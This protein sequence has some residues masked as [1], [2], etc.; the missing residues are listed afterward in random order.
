[1]ED[2]E[3]RTEE[4][5]PKR[6]RE[7]REKGQVA[8][9]GDLN[10]AVFFFIFT[11]LAGV[12]SQYILKNALNYLEYAL[13]GDFHISLSSNNVA[14]LLLNHMIRFVIFLLPFILIVLVVGIG[15]NLMQIG[16]IFTFEPIKPDLKRLNP[17][18]GFKNLFSKKA[19]FGLI[20]NILKLSLVLYLAYSSLNKSINSVI[21][22]SKLGSQKLFPFFVDFAKNVAF[23][24]AIVM[25]LLGIL[26]F[27]VERREYKKN[28]R[29]S[30]RELKDEFKEM[31]GS[32]EIKT[33]RQQRQ[34]QLAMTRMMSTIETATVV[35]TN[36]TH[37]AV[38]LRYDTKIDKAPLVLA[39]G[40]DYLANRIKEKAKEYDIPIM[41]DKALARVMYDKVEIG[42]YIPLELYKA[43]AE[44]LAHIYQM[45]ER[46]KGR[47]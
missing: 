13:S 26:D 28:L 47:I 20:K 21:N 41:E 22:S 44:I 31:E 5:T 1:M 9:S 33:A 38:V 25:L 12:L 8:K 24:I 4:A 43:I 27:V 7:A 36:P 18:E 45:K 37:I 15:V 35:V 39:K 34:R 6:L 46:N 10:A 42:D 40:V 11:I 2:R 19:F 32:P 16:F 23:N 14:S 30:V 17:I 29:M 3:N